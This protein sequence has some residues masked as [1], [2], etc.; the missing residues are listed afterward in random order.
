MIILYY[1]KLNKPKNRRFPLSILALA[2]VL[3]GREEYEIVDGNLEP[4]PDEVIRALCRSRRVE[5]LAVSVMPGPQMVSAMHSCKRIRAEFP[6]VPIVWGGYFPSVY[7]DA[8]L[9][10]A[11]VDYAARGQGENTL[12]ELIEA[13]RG[14]RHL[15][16]IAGLSYKDSDGTH[17]HNCERS[18][19]GPD[20]FPWSP[21]HRLPVE[22]Y[23]RPSYFGKRTAAHQASIGCPFQCRFC[24]I[25]VAFRQ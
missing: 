19:L 1:P 15:S 8:A 25:G 6:R 11:Y 2:A 7:K 18:M 21:F 14:K 20:A 22:K 23:L 13:L 5:L 4:N 16:T 24:A 9:N 12:L 10:A 3:E 17:R